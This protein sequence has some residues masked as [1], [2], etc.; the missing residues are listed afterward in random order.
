MDVMEIIPDSIITLGLIASLGDVNSVPAAK[1]K[2]YVPAVNIIGTPKIPFPE[3]VGIIMSKSRGVVS[4]LLLCMDDFGIT[5][6]TRIHS[7]NETIWMVFRISCEL[8]ST[9]L[10]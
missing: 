1:I 2:H 5:S 4:H 10:R 7:L 6:L 9:K 3:T 8:F